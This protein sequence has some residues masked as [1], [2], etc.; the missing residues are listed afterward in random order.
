MSIQT[1]LLKTEG[2]A[3][4]LIIAA[5]SFALAL[6]AIV[7]TLILFAIFQFDIGGST[8]ELYKYSITEV[9]NDEKDFASIL[10]ETIP[11]A[12]TALSVAIAFRA[13]LFNIG[14]QG[15]MMIGGCWAGIWAAAIVPDP[16]YHLTFMDNPLILPPPY[17]F[18]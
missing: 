14:G 7:V 10:D 9:L 11:L 18:M 5:I 1:D 13:G 16:K 4:A 2:R 15:Q 6:V 3:E 12:L 17:Y 8:S